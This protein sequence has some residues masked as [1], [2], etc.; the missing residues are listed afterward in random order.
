M[1]LMQMAIR[2]ASKAMVRSRFLFWVTC[3]RMFSAS[4]VG[5]KE[6][7]MGM[8]LLRILFF[9]IQIKKL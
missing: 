2:M 3:G 6:I 4:K 5:F 1:K 9:I 7:D 8:P